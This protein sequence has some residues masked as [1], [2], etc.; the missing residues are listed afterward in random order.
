MTVRG[1]RIGAPSES[2]ANNLLEEKGERGVVR[3]RSIT[4]TF[5]G[6]IFCDVYLSLGEWE[7]YE[8]E[9]RGSF[10]SNC[11]RPL[12]QRESVSGFMII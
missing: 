7:Q 8:A 1:A 3:I 6:Q 12:P 11:M 9:K 10:D 5:D 2:M 4:N